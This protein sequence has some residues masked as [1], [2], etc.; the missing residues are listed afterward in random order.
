[1][2]PGL[3]TVT[4]GSGGISGKTSQATGDTMSRATQG[5]GVDLNMGGADG[6]PWNM[7][8]VGGVAVVAVFAMARK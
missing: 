4:G 5:G 8:V 1:M 2:L 7:I 6:I 3:G